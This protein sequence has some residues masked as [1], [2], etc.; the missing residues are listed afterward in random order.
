MLRPLMI[1]GVGGSG[2][3]TVRRLRQSL[4]RQLR[5]VEGWSGDIPKAWQMVWIDWPATQESDSIPMLPDDDYLGLWPS[6]QAAWSGVFPALPDSLQS[7]THADLLAG[8]FDK[9]LN[10][11]GGGGGQARAAGRNLGSITMSQMKRKLDHWHAETMSDSAMSEL[12]T[13]EQ[14]LGIGSDGRRNSPMAF[15]ISSLAG[16]T[17]AGLF[18]EVLTAMHAVDPAYSAPTGIA[19]ML[20]TADVFG[21][22]NPALIE[23]VSANGLAAAMEVT[24]G[25]LSHGRSQQS[26]EM[27]S[28]QGVL[29]GDGK[30]ACT[31]NFLIGR[32]NT[33][34]VT[35]AGQSEVYQAVG[36]CLSSLVLDDSMMDDLIRFPLLAAFT[37]V[38]FGDATRLKNE[39]DASQT[40][41]FSG[42]GLAKVAL[43]TDRLGDYAAQ[44]MATD[45][46]EQLM[47]PEF[48]PDE[49][50]NIPNQERIEQS[51]DNNFSRFLEN[52]GLNEINPADDVLI[53]LAGDQPSITPNLPFSLIYS[54]S[55]VSTSAQWAHA[56]VSH[57]PA[58]QMNG[59]EWQQTFETYWNTQRAAPLASA[60]GDLW[61]QAQEW[62]SAIQGR[63]TDL[64]AESSV[65]LGLR[66]TQ[67]LLDRLR[68][69]VSSARQE[70]T[71]E[72]GELQSWSAGQ[73]SEA[74]RQLSVGKAKM[75][76]QDGAV[77]EAIASIQNGVLF[78]SAA[79]R[80]EVAA[81]LLGDLNENFLG[82][83]QDMIS[84]WFVR[85]SAALSS[86]KLPDGRSNP[87]KIM[88]RYSR[89][90]PT[91]FRPG[92]VEKMLISIDDFESEVERAI[93]SGLP[94]SQRGSWKILARNR[95]GLGL[96]LA[97]G[98]GRQ[99]LIRQTA[100][101]IPIQTKAASVQAAPT[102]ASF[103]APRD[104]MS[105]LE[106][107][108]SGW[109]GIERWLSS[110]KAAELG[111]FLK[112]DLHSYVNSGDAQTRLSREQAL[113]AAFTEAT[114]AAAP[115][116]S[117]K[118][119]VANLVHGKTGQ[120]FTAIL[121][122]IPFPPGDPLHDQ[123][124]RQLLVSGLANEANAD[125]H[126]KT[127]AVDSITFLTSS[128]NA[129]QAVVFDN[130]MEPAASDWMK[131]RANKQL[132]EIFWRWRR[133]RP[134]SESLP[135]GREDTLPQMLRGWFVAD[136][137]GQKRSSYD[138][139]A[140]PKIELWCDQDG[141]QAFPYPLLSRAP[142]LPR[143]ARD[144]GENFQYLSAVLKS[145]SLAL[146]EVY[147]SA[148]LNSLLPY[149]RLLDL[150]GDVQNELGDWIDDA[151]PAPPVPELAAG[152]TGMSANERA[153]AVIRRLETLRG[154]WVAHLD[155][156]KTHPKYETHTI[157]A[158][159]EIARD[160]LTALDEILSIARN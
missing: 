150:G 45:L 79:R 160:V 32:T 35:F 50:A 145:I 100:N 30:F 124:R 65:E 153:D 34:G 147:T 12:G 56:V 110:D 154:E 130:V 19:T 102:K 121:S 96:D 128:A 69:Q 20:Y 152:D 98:E 131:R 13:L 80:H 129:M 90:T 38:A 126:F 43:G 155:Q 136:V 159:F 42:I 118:Q 9:T 91:Q 99:S 97:T 29:T 54:R 55:E 94:E 64:V 33:A 93:S 70:L 112:T 51:A 73:I 83:L 1:V 95:A 52:S 68:N 26:R 17:G 113:V 107:S 3:K 146:L 23:Q 72:S 60:E 22:L 116:V 87:F 105:I 135:F 101:W 14:C 140:G 92:P 40:F 141:W 157:P 7:G 122:A 8:W 66:V 114:I 142:G 120:E 44:I 46:V 31:Y 132:R 63:L 85:L 134:L 115:L 123:L 48:L 137:L 59:A 6:G 47:W 71:I 53:A 125:R 75:T 2:G 133:A 139:D 27:L 57:A 103:T 58:D 111:A 61:T 143:P 149:H 4:Q 117:I 5:R 49:G 156:Y 104:L 62:T 25:V 82:P 138:R 18:M 148:S 158:S 127:T 67:E 78:A 11:G 108:D 106:G 36:E 21:T 76:A 37:M 39:S 24:S 77:Q 88:P 28:S 144:G 86:N 16:G 74:L 151:K 84:N 119:S 109:T 15:L 41:P 10:V 81:E 89:P